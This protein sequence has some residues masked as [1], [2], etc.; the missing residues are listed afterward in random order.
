METTIA[1]QDNKAAYLANREAWKTLAHDKANTARDYIEYIIAQALCLSE[2]LGEDEARQWALRK[3]R[4]AFTPSRRDGRKTLADWLN[5]MRYYF[6]QPF[7]TTEADK[8]PFQ[9]FTV[10]LFDE[11][12]ME[13]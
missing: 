2:K 6:R 1:A 12:R 13:G 10:F 9:A 8:E 4:A 11:I 7:N 5:G 3:L